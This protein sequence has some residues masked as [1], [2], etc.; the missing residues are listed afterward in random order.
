MVALAEETDTSV[1]PYA[2]PSPAKLRRQ[3]LL[4]GEAR[5]IVLGRTHD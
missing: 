4:M 5:D 1:A 3:N 2:A